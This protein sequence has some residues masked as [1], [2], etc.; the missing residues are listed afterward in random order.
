MAETL[1]SVRDLKKA[2][3]SHTVLDG[4]SFD[5]PAGEIIGLL[6]PNGCGKTTLMKILTGLIHDYSGEVLV[7]GHAPGA[8]TK[9]VVSYLSE[10]NF[11][12]DWM[13]VKDAIEYYADFFKDFDSEK[14]YS[15][16]RMF[17]LPEKQK[18]K[19]LSKGMK[20]KL[21]LLLTMSRRA[22]LYLLDEPIGGVDPAARDAILEFIIKNHEP[23]STIIVS[24]HLIADLENTFERV[25]FIGEGHLKVYDTVESIHASGKSVEEVFKE[26]FRYAWEA[27]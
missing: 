7:D 4:L 21:L 6:G 18:V 12:H 22:K 14:A 9:S 26:V 16:A 23:G 1:V 27:D 15:L 20:E 5:V 25:V 2:Y 11:L 10:N 17:S 19:T 24:T 8:Y 13:R 3:G